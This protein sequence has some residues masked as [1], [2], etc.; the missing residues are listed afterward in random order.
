MIQTPEELEAG[1]SK[2]IP[3]TEG[4]HDSVASYAAYKEAMSIGRKS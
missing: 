2:I 1:R 4:S 3:R